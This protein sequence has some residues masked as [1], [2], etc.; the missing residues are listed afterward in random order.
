VRGQFDLVYEF[1][2]KRA[3]AMAKPTERHV[4]EVFAAPLGANAAVFPNMEALHKPYAILQPTIDVLLQAFEGCSAVADWL[5]A[6]GKSYDTTNAVDIDPRGIGFL[7]SFKMLVGPRSGMTYL[8]AALGLDVVELY[9]DDR[10]QRWVSKWSAAGY[11][12]IYGSKLPPELVERAI[13][14]VWGRDY[15]GLRAS[16]L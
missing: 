10:H 3:Y 2:P 8:A 14:D 11:Q 15:D 5:T 7:L 1:N 12:M 13:E 6:H 9:P 16:G 4:S